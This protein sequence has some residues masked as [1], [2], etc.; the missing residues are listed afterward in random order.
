VPS[1][2]HTNGRTAN[3]WRWVLLAVAAVAAF[4]AGAALVHLGAGLLVHHHGKLTANERLKAENDARTSIIQLLAG[5]GLL[6]G[7]VY[8]VRTFALT[9]QSQRTTRFSTAVGQIGDKDSEAVRVG[10]VHSLL[11]LA[12]ESS[13]FWP[14]VEEVLSAVLRSANRSRVSVATDVQAAATVL[15]RRPDRALEDRGPP[16]DLRGAHLRR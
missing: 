10:G 6:G 2:G 15:G 16:V 12:S 9:R 14:P 7:F 11:M 3:P 8:T 1:F 13:E 5:A 4:V